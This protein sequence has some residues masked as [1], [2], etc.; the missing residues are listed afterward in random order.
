MTP[1]GAISALD[2]AL[3]VTG[4]DITLRRTTGTN[5]APFDVESV[6]AIVRGYEPAELVGSITQGDSKIILSPTEMQ[7]RQWTWPPREGDI[8]IIRDKH[9]RVEA[10]HSI[11]MGETLVRVELSV[12]G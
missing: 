1:Q 8:V 7:A 3:T 2:R 9:R 12:K 4:E 6:R 5:Q 11:Y 10:A